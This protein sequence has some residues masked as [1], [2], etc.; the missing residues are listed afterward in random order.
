MTRQ[1]ATQWDKDAVR[2][3]FV[4][5]NRRLVFFER[6]VDPGDKVPFTTCTTHG[7]KGWASPRAEH[8]Q[9]LQAL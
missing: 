3:C 9:E 1:T 5:E 4:L 7:T 6:C 2:S 8:V